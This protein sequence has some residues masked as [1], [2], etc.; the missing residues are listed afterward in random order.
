MC[1]NVHKKKTVK[2]MVIGGICG[3]VTLISF[4]ISASTNDDSIRSISG[5][6]GAIALLM[7]I[8]AGVMYMVHYTLAWTKGSN[9]SQKQNNEQ[10][11]LIKI[12]QLYKEGLL[13][14]EEF[15]TQKIK[16]LKGKDS[17]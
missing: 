8:L 5:P 10:E 17:K 13:T 4:N 16:I 14:K 2:W 12:G 1:D 15:E 11:A 9:N 6:I 3:C 7:S